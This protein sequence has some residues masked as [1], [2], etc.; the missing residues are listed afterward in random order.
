MKKIKLPDFKEF[1]SDSKHCH[2]YDLFYKWVMSNVLPISR[3]LY[4]RE[5]P[6]NKVID[7]RMIGLTEEDDSLLEDLLFKW[8]VKY[9]KYSK[10]RAASALSIEKFDIG[11]KIYIKS[12]Y[13][14]VESG[15]VYIENNF[16]RNIK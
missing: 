14:E 15:Y 5:V 10:K 6:T 8:L 4:N 12:R 1:E 13:P 3:I 9:H 2:P 7:V 16:L 11:P